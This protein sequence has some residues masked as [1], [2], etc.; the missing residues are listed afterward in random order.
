MTQDKSKWVCCMKL[1]HMPSPAQLSQRTVS[2]RHISLFSKTPCSLVSTAHTCT[3][4]ICLWGLGDCKK[5]EIR[6]VFCYPCVCVFDFVIGFSTQLI[7]WSLSY[8]IS[9]LFPLLPKFSVWL[10]KQCAINEYKPK[11]KYHFG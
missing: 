2:P 4:F 9:K 11:I 8:N 6:R 7:Q 1:A 5:C 3:L 10:P